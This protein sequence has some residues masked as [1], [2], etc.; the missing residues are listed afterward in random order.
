MLVHFLHCACVFLFPVSGVL[1]K[2]INPNMMACAV[3]HTETEDAPA[4]V[5]VV[6]LDTVT[7]R[8]LYRHA[9]EDA[10]GP[11]QMVFSENAL[12]YSYV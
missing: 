7:G 6:V 8:S 9:H 12:V 3:S 5:D 4:V 11:I 2:Y 1:L 10:A